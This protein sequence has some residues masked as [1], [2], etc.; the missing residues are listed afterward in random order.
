MFSISGGGGFSPV[1]PLLC[2]PL[3]SL[4]PSP[5]PTATPR[6]RLVSGCCVVRCNLV[7]ELCPSSPT[8]RGSF[9]IYHGRFVGAAQITLPRVTTISLHLAQKGIRIRSLW[10]EL[11]KRSN[12]RHVVSS[13]FIYLAR[14]FFVH[15]A[16]TNSW[17][18]ASP[19]D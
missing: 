18:P 11:H 10:V 1:S 12:Y 13:L 14:T 19:G 8:P 5:Q 16:Y 17:P 6:R 15:S 3:D 9:V 2:T 4:P 7:D